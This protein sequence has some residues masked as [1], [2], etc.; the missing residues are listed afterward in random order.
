MK[1]V[2][3]RGSSF[4]VDFN[5][6]CAMYECVAA[7]NSIALVEHSCHPTCEY[8]IPSKTVGVNICVCDEAY[9]YVLGFRCRVDEDG[10][11]CRGAN[12]S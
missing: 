3:D 11:Y 2:S 9:L 10:E 12:L 6:D 7:S 8:M 5:V 4:G 1:E